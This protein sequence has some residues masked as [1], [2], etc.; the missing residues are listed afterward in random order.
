MVV[1]D[2][3]MRQFPQEAFELLTELLGAEWVVLYREQGDAVFRAA[4]VCNSARC[5]QIVHEVDQR[6]S[7]PPA[8]P[9]G[10]P[11]PAE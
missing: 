10:D 4:S 9:L 5:T 11:K 7:W 6:F 8:I 1:R 2:G 3:N